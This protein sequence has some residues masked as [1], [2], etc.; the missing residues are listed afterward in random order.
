MRL[1]IFLLCPLSFACVGS[2]PSEFDPQEPAEDNAALASCADTIPDFFVDEM[3]CGGCHQAGSVLGGGFDLRSDDVASRVNG[4]V[5]QC[6][7]ELLADPANPEQSTLVQWV[8]GTAQCDTS[9][10]TMMPP[11]GQNL[12]ADEIQC[13]LVW[14][15]NL[16]GQQDLGGMQ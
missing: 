10:S 5:G 4:V 13:L 14:I 12:S 11:I 9:D 16:D 15:D 2:L 6:P 1:F 3:R 7:E 8:R